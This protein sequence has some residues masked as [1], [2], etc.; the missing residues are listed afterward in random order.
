MKE[1]RCVLEGTLFEFSGWCNIYIS[2]T[3]IHEYTDVQWD[4]EAWVSCSEAVLQDWNHWM[5]S[6][7]IAA[8][9][10]I[11]LDVLFEIL[12]FSAFA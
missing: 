8:D 6:F 2:C 10:F 7:E 4:L 3:Q 1:I 11:I 12:T 9:M 5:Y